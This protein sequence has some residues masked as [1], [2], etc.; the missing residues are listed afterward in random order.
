MKPCISQ[1]TTLKNPFEAD[2][3]VYKRRRLDRRRALADQ[4]RNVSPESFDGRR[5]L[6]SRVGGLTPGRGGVSRRF[7][8][9]SRDGADRALGS[10]PAAAGALARA[11]SAH[12]DRHSRFCASAGPRGIR[13]GR[14]RRS[15]KPPSWP[16][17]S[18]CGSRSSFKSRPP[19]ALASRRHSP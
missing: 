18:A 8:A 16:R 13:P 4:A 17:R 15:A 7:V 9:L 2:L 6:A 11:G 19:S 3:A 14:R 12:A 5:R 10:F 1:A